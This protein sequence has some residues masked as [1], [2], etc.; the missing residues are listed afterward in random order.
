MKKLLF[1]IPGI[2]LFVNV[3]AQHDGYH[4]V[5][6]GKVIES[7]AMTSKI[8]GE[9]VKYSIYLP[10]DYTASERRYPVVYLLHGYT[11]NETG[12][13]QFGEANRIADKGI[14]EGTIPPMIIVMPDAKITFYM[15]DYKDEF[16]YEDMFFEEFIPFI[17]GQYRTRPEKQFRGVSG[18]SMG[19]HGSLLYSIKHPDVFSACAAF[20][21]AV[22]TDEEIIGMPVDLY[23]SLFKTI[24]ELNVEGEQRLTDH[25]HQNSVL[26][27]VESTPVE[28]LKEVRYYIDC[29]DDDWLTSGNTALHLLLK[30]K[31]IPHEFRVRDGGH[32]WEY[33]RTG[34]PEG[35]TFIGESFH[36]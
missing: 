26:S 28:S 21:A 29:G 15:N 11:D 24:F 10:P 9:D 18:L 1:S 7:L 36:R 33:W 35:L 8:L 4:V 5:Q 32:Q 20:S 30:K 27:L 23:N 34:L 3:I 2:I 22:M 17:D 6:N 12:W 16:R 13:I 14:T 31:G 19:G 25:Y